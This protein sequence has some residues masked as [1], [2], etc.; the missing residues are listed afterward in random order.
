MAAMETTLVVSG[1]DWS[2]QPRSELGLPGELAYEYDDP[3]RSQ[4]RLQRHHQRS[5]RDLGRA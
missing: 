4:S 5:V 1:W 3:I 2:Y